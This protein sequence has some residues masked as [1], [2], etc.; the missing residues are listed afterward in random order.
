M[1]PDLDDQPFPRQ[2]GHFG[3][4]V[5]HIVVAQLVQRFFLLPRNIVFLVLAEPMQE[6]QTIALTMGDDDPIPASFAPA[7]RSD[8]LLYQKA[9]QPRID[10]PVLDFSG[11]FAESF[12]RQTFALCPTMELEILKHANSHNVSPGDIER[13]DKN[14]SGVL[15]HAKAALKGGFA[16]GRRSGRADVLYINATCLQVK[17]WP[18]NPR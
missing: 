9:A 18:L 7:C 11:G 15:E 13:K 3:V 10:Q 8:P 17:D 5:R 16:P 2:L 14:A 6:D 4:A 12:V 1:T